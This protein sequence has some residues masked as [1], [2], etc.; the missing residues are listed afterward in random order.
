[1]KKDQRS[2]TWRQRKKTN[3]QKKEAMKEKGETQNSGKEKTGMNGPDNDKNSTK[4]AT[5]D[6]ISPKKDGHM[7]FVE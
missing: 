2:Q 7:D 3:N 4:M 5:I 1:M 6:K